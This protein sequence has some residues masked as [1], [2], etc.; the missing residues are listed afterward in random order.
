MK[1]SK[2]SVKSMAQLDRRNFVRLLPAA[3]VVLPEV[4]RSAVAQNPIPAQPAPATPA[5]GRITVEI[6]HEAEKMIGL[7]LTEAQEKMA[8]AGANRNLASYEGLRRIEV[9]LDTELATLFHPALPGKR[10]SKTRTPLRRARV[11]TP[12]FKTVADLAFCT[13]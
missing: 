6:L 3:G 10:Y 1:K 2:F 5:P 13:V 8:L 9:P 11:R 12:A 4:F 7:E